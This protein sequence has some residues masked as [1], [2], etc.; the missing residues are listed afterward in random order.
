M[1]QFAE[2]WAE[3]EL[4]GK[5]G[6]RYAVSN[7]GR[8]KSFTEHLHEGKLL[9]LNEKNGYKA[10]N[11]REY[12]PEGKI[13]HRVAYI[14]RLVAENF[15]EQPPGADHVIF[16]NHNH[17]VPHVSNLQWVSRAE[18]LE[19]TRKSP[20]VQRGR[21]Q[22]Q[23]KN[24]ERDGRKLRATDVLHLKRKLARGNTRVKML[25]KQFNVSE[26]TIYRIARKEN[27]GHL[28]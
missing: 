3:I 8:V 4:G 12:T 2:R 26:T 14:H 11:Y 17:Q 22:A 15:L 1:E 7:F 19:H 10:I 13:R 6:Q 24:R 21:K 20:A 5:A 16:V 18:M 25:A 9:K 28:E 23:Q 27:W